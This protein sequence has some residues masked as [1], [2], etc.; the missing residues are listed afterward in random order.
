[1]KW[2]PAAAHLILDHP[3]TRRAAELPKLHGIDDEPLRLAYQRVRRLDRPI[4]PMA[5]RL[6][7]LRSW[8][9]GLAAAGAGEPVRAVTLHQIQILGDRAQ[10][11]QAGPGVRPG[12]AAEAFHERGMA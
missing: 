7:V 4:D 2:L 5:V 1:Q 10:H 9:E 11:T 8:P 12:L 3:T 6:V